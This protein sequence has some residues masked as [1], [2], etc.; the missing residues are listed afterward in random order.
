MRGQRRTQPDLVEQIKLIGATGDREPACPSG[1]RRG[2]LAVAHCRCRCAFHH[3]QQ[4]IDPS[5]IGTERRERCRIR[6]VVH[7]AHDEVPLVGTGLAINDA[8]HGFGLLATPTIVCRVCGGTV[9]GAH[10]EWHELRFEVVYEDLHQAAISRGAKDV[11]FQQIAS[12]C[13][14]LNLGMFLEPEACD[15]LDRNP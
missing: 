2:I 15:V 8:D 14:T 3:V 13:G 1:V 11:D 9:N 7:V 5:A 12:E 4:T 10:V 6:I